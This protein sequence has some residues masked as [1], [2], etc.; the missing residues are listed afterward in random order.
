MT[1]TLSTIILPIAL[2]FLSGGGIVAYFRYLETKPENR[3]KARQ[4]NATA[5]V[6]LGEGWSKLAEKLE[7]RLEASERANEARIKGLE[8]QI[9]DNE[10]EHRRI[11]EEKDQEIK[12]L[13]RRI[14]VLERELEKA[15]GLPPG[16][17]EVESR[18]EPEGK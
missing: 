2:A 16:T 9:A 18:P 13:K 12:R 7:R 1:V 15:T 17:L 3:Q 14:T 5:E 8:R 11:V 4:I 10:K 6:T